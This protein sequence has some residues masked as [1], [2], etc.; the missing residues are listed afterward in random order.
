MENVFWNLYIAIKSA[1]DGKYL[2]YVINTTSD[3]IQRMY[4]VKTVKG[5]VSNRINDEQGSKLVTRK[6]Q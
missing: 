2:E 3:D 4:F 6:E 1:T 5:T